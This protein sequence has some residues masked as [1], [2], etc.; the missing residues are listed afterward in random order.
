LHCVVSFQILSIKDEADQAFAQVA[1]Y[2]P[3]NYWG[4]FF[5]K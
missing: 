3:D 2:A 4:S 5:I 1:E